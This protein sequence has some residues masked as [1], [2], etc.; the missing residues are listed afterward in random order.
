MQLNNELVWRQM[1]GFIKEGKTIDTKQL[2]TTAQMQL[3]NELVWRQMSDFIKE[4]KTIDTKQLWKIHGQEKI[5]PV[6]A[7]KRFLAIP[8]PVDLA[9][10]VFEYSDVSDEF[11]FEFI[12]RLSE[13]CICSWFSI[14][15]VGPTMT[16]TFRESPFHVNV[17]VSATCPLTQLHP[18]ATSS[19]TGM[20]YMSILF[21][22]ADLLF[23]QT[24]LQIY[25][26]LHKPK[27]DLL[28]RQCPKSSKSSPRVG[29]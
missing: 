13:G 12:T 15:H 25:R 2:W 24:D 11:D 10:M 21:E 28:C 26:H 29:C 27:T 23:A 14:V 6:L 4:G 19:S 20:K 5:H 1:S 3:N 8:L 7:Q 17:S 9:K 22:T 16:I 18:T